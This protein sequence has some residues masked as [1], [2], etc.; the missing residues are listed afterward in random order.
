MVAYCSEELRIVTPTTSENVTPV[1][2]PQ[3]R[4][5][6]A[7]P[8]LSELNCE[9]L[10]SIRLNC[11]RNQVRKSKS[12]KGVRY[13]GTKCKLCTTHF[14]CRD[15][16]GKVSNGH[17]VGAKTLYVCDCCDI[18]LCQPSGTY[19]GCFETF[20]TTQRLLEPHEYYKRRLKKAAGAVPTKAVKF[21]QFVREYARLC[22][23]AGNRKYP[24]V[25][26]LNTLRRTYGDFTLEN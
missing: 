23:S 13:Q 22:E 20:H 21:A 25:D 7:R 4:K 6:K 5:Y 9:P 16:K 11:K 3:P 15:K 26:Q 1:G 8:K 24:T 12:S 2:T 17:K 19:P 10:K 14:Y 18:P